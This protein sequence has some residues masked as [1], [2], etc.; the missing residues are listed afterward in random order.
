MLNSLNSSDSSLAVPTITTT[1]IYNPSKV[2]QNKT[3]GK[4]TKSCNC[5]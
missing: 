1:N 3:N 2:M 5:Y 4:T